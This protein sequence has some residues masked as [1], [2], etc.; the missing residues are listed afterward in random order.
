MTRINIEIEP[1]L[2]KQAKLNALL[3]N[4]TLIEYIHEALHLKVSEDRKKSK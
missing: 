4:K 2:H 1:E 3:Q